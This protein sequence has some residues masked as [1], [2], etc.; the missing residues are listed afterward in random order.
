[1]T[2]EKLL[3]SLISRSHQIFPPISF[4]SQ[5]DVRNIGSLLAKTTGHMYSVK[6]RMLRCI[7][8]THHVDFPFRQHS[9]DIQSKWSC[10]FLNILLFNLLF[11]GSTLKKIITSLQDSLSC[12]WHHS[13]FNFSLIYFNSELGLEPWTLGTM[14][15]PVIWSHLS[16]L[17]FMISSYIIKLV[18]FL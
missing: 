8:W 16:L 4:Q 15:K 18:N 6:D 7:S 13:T 9:P 2:L 1:M 5:E 3:S 10:S 14:S 11:T 17:L 12:M